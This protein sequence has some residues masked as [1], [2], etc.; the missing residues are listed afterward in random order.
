[1][2][3]PMK[4]SDVQAARRKVARQTKQLGADHY[5]VEETRKRGEAV[6]KGLNGGKV[7]GPDNG[8]PED[9]DP[10]VEENENSEEFGIVATYARGAA[11]LKRLGKKAAP[12]PERLG[13]SDA[14]NERNLANDSNE[15]LAIGPVVFR[16]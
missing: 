14:T 13:S 9:L 3:N 7:D 2:K 4:D 11:E 15:R 10:D 6:L 12:L 1:M 16:S 8:E 5:S